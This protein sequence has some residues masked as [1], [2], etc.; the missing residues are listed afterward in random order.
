MV[1]HSIIVSSWDDRLVKEAHE[2][3]VRLFDVPRWRA[4]SYAGLVSP[5]VG[6]LVNGERSFFIAPD[7]SKEGWPESDLG[8]DLRASF[9]AY[10]RSKRYDDGSTS[11]KWVEVQFADENND[12]RVLQASGDGNG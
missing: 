1:H 6:G 10:L 2:T 12:N 7:G 4:Y 5:V 9:I 3:A 11:L 8:D